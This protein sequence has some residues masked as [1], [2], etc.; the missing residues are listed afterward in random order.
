MDI[1]YVAGLFDGE[2]CII[3]ARQEFPNHVR[4]QLHVHIA[5][6]DPRALI[7]VQKECGGSF[8]WGTQR[9]NPAHRP[10]HSWHVTSRAA[11]DFLRR[12]E[13]YLIVKRDEAKLAIE[14]Q[15]G[16]C[17]WG[18]SGQPGPRIP[19]DEIARRQDLRRRI[20]ALKH[21]PFDPADYG[22]VA[23]SG[24]IQNGQSRAKQRGRPRSVGVCNESMPPAIPFG[25]AK[26]D[27]DLHGDMQSAAEMTAPQEA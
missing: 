25:E 21:I 7:A 3:I 1:R 8:H 17:H 15:E 10:L 14:F 20:A 19:A 4:Y 16:M 9:K 6:S 13:P 24:D 2:G 12:V 18:S 26:R 23:K 22:M 11:L 27:S 5:M